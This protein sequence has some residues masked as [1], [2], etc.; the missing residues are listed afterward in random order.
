MGN[1]GTDKL[2]IRKFGWSEEL[3]RGRQATPFLGSVVSAFFEFL[4]VN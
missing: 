2:Q 4:A 3:A 1:S